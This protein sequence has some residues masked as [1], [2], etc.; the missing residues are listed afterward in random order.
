[1]ETYKINVIAK[2]HTD[3]P[4]KFGLPRQSGIVK[5][6]AG[7]IVFEPEYRDYS[8]VRDLEQYS[9]IWVLWIFSRA[10]KG[11]K[12]SPTVRPPRLGGNERIGVFA[13]RS[14]YR[15]NP[16]GISALKLEKVENNKKYGPVIYVSGIDMCD[17]TPIIDIKPYI[18]FTDS[19]PNALNGFAGEHYG[20]AVDVK[21]PETVK[22]A[23]PDDVLNQ[24]YGV[25]SEDPRPRY[26]DDPDRI[27]GF[28]FCGY[29]IKFQ[30][31]GNNLSVISV[32]KLT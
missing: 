4:D 3:F 23:L 21:I 14:P 28:I 26:H 16:V 8:A 30:V 12:W 32:F 24:L 7:R 22:A 20:K 27:Y 18:S 15:P 1:M 9:H 10:E 17:A 29:E 5:G 2:I 11:K 13:T 31:R 25:L 6:L 19:Y